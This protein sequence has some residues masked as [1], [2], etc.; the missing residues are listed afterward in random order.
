MTLN[1]VSAAGGVGLS[2]RL[3]TNDRPSEGPETVSSAAT[4]LCKSLSLLRVRRNHPGFGLVSSANG[5]SSSRPAER[6][7][8]TVCAELPDP[9]ALPVAAL[10]LVLLLLERPPN[11]LRFGAAVIASGSV[12]PSS[13]SDTRIAGT[14]ICSGVVLPV[15]SSCDERS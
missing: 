9:D 12:V 11:H 7:S 4:A 2:L 5:L 6:G 1:E 3:T 15:G 10:A 8:G 14:F 13:N